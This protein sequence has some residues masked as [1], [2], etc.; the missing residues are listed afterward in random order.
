MFR[1]NVHIHKKKK[2]KETLIFVKQTY[3]KYTSSVRCET[4]K[5]IDQFQGSINCQRM[6]SFKSGFVGQIDYR[7]IEW[8]SYVTS[9]NRNTGSH[10]CYICY[11][12]CRKLR[13]ILMLNNIFYEYVWIRGHGS[14]II[15]LLSTSIILVDPSR[16]IRLKRL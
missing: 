14:G 8:Q 6:V 12:R 7:L 11:I 9:I 3:S 15:N 13:L 1:N 5:L 4:T 2:K 16:S 10:A